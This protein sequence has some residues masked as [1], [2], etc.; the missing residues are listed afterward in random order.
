[1]RGWAVATIRGGR[2]ATNANEA[3]STT[4]A[5]TEPRKAV[6]L[7]VTRGE[8]PIELAVAGVRRAWFAT[9]ACPA[10]RT[11]VVIPVFNE[12]RWVRESVRRVLS[13]HAGCDVVMVDD[14]SSDG[15]WQIIQELGTAHSIHA[16]EHKV[17]RGKGAALRTGIAHAL[18]TGA[19]I[20][21][22]HD[23]DLEY[24]PSEHAQ[25]LAPMLD[26]R[27]DAVIGS[28]FIGQTHR[29]LYY[30]HSVAN[31]VITTMCNMA[32]NL[33]LTD[34]EC[35]CKAFHRRVLEQI[36]LTEDRFGIEIELIA[37]VAQLKIAQG[38]GQPARP[39]RVYEVPV[40]YSGRT[41]EEGKKISWRDGV[42]AIGCIMKYSLF[43]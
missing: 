13:H 1:V 14:G 38:D 29:V 36:T 40:S 32:T 18:A 23:A 25:L 10:V 28:R 7:V 37:K 33:N 12:A 26:G 8:Y 16:L 19:E 6:E 17:N 42:A 31:S 5:R 22:I 41:Y 15:T 35:C 11:M 27:A 21:L 34:V 2:T 43:S 39:V 3:E 4:N 9:Y 24:D 20:V 30:W